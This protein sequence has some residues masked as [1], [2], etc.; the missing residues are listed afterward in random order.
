VLKEA[1]WERIPSN[2]RKHF[3]GVKH[4][5]KRKINV[6]CEREVEEE[7]GKGTSK[8]FFCEMQSRECMVTL[9]D[10]GIVSHIKMRRDAVRNIYYEHQRGIN[11]NTCAELFLIEMHFKMVAKLFSL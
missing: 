3:T 10:V 4:F 11:L 1:K 6:S 9:S 2:M 7:K 8:K 5:E